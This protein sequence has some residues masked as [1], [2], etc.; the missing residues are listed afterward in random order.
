MYKSFKRIRNL[1]RSYCLTTRFFFLSI[2]PNICIEAHATTIHEAATGAAFTKPKTSIHDI[3]TSK[4][5]Y[6]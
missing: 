1:L 6:D 2:L 5:K 3:L 4:I